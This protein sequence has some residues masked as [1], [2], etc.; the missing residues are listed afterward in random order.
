M[1]MKR[2][3]QFTF[4]VSPYDSE[5]IQPSQPISDSKMSWSGQRS[6]TR[7]D[8]TQVDGQLLRAST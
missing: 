7:R 3:G 6:E 1:H 8:E 5:S 2:E 4:Q